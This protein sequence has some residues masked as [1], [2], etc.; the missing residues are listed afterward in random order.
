MKK[1]ERNYKK[2]Q[3]EGM[4][5]IKK[6]KKEGGKENQVLLFDVIDINYINDDF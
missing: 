3:N 4:K 6:G 1:S 2:G 5:V